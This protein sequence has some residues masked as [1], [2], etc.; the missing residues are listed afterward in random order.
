MIMSNYYHQLINTLQTKEFEHQERLRIIAECNRASEEARK[1]RA[2][3][4]SYL[5]SYFKEYQ[6][7]FDEALSAIHTAFD[8]GDANGVIAGTNQITRKLGGKVY[9]DNMN[10]FKDFLF[11]NSTDI[12]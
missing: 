1:F 5:I 12:L 2:E 7:C 6:D 3:L 10:E 11:D 9:Y 8:T 4:E